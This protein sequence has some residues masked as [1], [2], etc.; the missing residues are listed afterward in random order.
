MTGGNADCAMA[1]ITP[2][3]QLDASFGNGGRATYDSRVSNTDMDR[4][5]GCFGLALQTDGKILAAGYADVD[6]NGDY[7]IE[8][9]RIIGD[10]IF[11]NG[12]EP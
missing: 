2:D 11:A 3:G 12:F 8:V 9:V 5:N 10:T 7:G 1:R 6:A 4:A